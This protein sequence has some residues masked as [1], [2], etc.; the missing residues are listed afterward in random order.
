MQNQKTFD[1]LYFCSFHLR[2][3]GKNG[4]WC[5][6]AVHNVILGTHR[7]SAVYLVV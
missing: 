7:V 6:N 5:R 2:N 3:V 1:K 4:K